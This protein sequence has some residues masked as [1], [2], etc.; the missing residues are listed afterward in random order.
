MKRNTLNKLFFILLATLAM[1]C[2]TKKAIVT[3][4]VKTEPVAVDSRKADNILLLKSKDL[5][6]TTLSLKAKANLDINGNTNNVSM[7]IRM[8]KG[9]RIWVS[10]TAFAG[11]EVARA[12]ITP[13]SIKVRNN[14]QSTYLK[15]PFS[16][17]H[18]FTGKPVNFQMVQALFSGNTIT[19]LLVEESDVAQVNGVWQ[20][21]GQKQDL[22]YHVLFNT[23]LKVKESNLSDVRSG[24]ALTAVYDNYQ[25]VSDFLFP[26]NMR[27]NSMAGTQKININLDFTNIERNVTLEFPF[28]VPG[29]YELV[30]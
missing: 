30:N 2:K 16:Y 8:E 10:I 4:P 15:K 24:Q 5:L 17:V 13:D 21:K 11:I 26:S 7:N 9:K 25:K 27:V 18:R 14:L 12:L 23:L 19:D 20:I 29:K 3:A 6:F 22:L 1:A 28:N